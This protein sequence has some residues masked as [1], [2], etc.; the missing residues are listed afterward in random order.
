MTISALIDAR[1]SPFHGMPPSLRVRPA[2]YSCHRRFEIE[3]THGRRCNTVRMARNGGSPMVLFDLVRR[4][5]H[6]TVLCSGPP[7]SYLPPLDDLRFIGHPSRQNRT[8]STPPERVSQA[9]AL[10]KRRWLCEHRPQHTAKSPPMRS[11]SCE[12]F[13]RVV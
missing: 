12:S 5:M 11:S 1:H 2:N 7:L 6:G 13:T 10:A 3:Y 9:C 8:H 4:H